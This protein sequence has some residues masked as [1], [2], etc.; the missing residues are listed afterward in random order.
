MEKNPRKRLGC[1][2]NGEEDIKNHPFF[3]SI[4]WDKL[5]SKHVIPPFKPKVSSDFDAS[6]FD[7][8]FTNE[9]VTN[10]DNSKTSLE[11]S[12]DKNLSESLQQKFK[13]FSFDGDKK[14][15]FLQ[16]P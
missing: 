14:G 5:M 13:G 7:P 2:P 6:N 9:D 4:D 1:G 12:K 15:E 11:D 8:V 10:E 3:A 16:N